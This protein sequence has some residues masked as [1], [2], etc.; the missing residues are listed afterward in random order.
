L[1]FLSTVTVGQFPH[2]WAV[3]E[4]EAR[5]GSGLQPHLHI[6]FSPRREE[7]ELDRTPAQWFAKVAA[8][9]ADP[10][11][12]G[13]RKDRSWDTKGRLYDVREAVALLTNAALAREGL[14]L[15]VDH[16]SLEARGL[17]R[18]AARYGSAHDKT[19]LDQ[20]MRYRQQ[21]LATYAGWQE[22]A[23]QLRSLE[24]Q[25]VKDLARDHVWRFDKS[26]ARVLERQQSLA[27]TFALAMG[28][29]QPTRPHSQERTPP[30]HRVCVRH[31]LR[32]LAA[33]LE[34]ADEAPAG[35]ALRVRLYE[36]EREE[37]RGL[38]W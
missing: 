13:V 18:D 2:S 16:R 8:R 9:G 5:D 4:P 37:D 15:A 31:Q 23:L 20:T 1:D 7:V 34:R 6:L 29:R 30:H 33:A 14:A 11:T 35:A 10:L 26:P 24:R 17:S 12:G 32:E 25:Y 38:G 3:H 27:R 22:Q 28:D 21:Q 36:R 19:D